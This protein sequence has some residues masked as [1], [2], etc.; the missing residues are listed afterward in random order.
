[1]ARRRRALITIGIGVLFGAV[2]LLAP[3]APGLPPDPELDEWNE[4]DS[5]LDAGTVEA[6]L[7]WLQQRLNRKRWNCYNYAVDTKTF[8]VFGNGVRAHPGKGKKWPNIGKNITAQQMCDKVKA[9]AKLDL[10][11]NVDWD[12][13]DPIPDLPDGENLVALGAKAGPKGGGGDYHWWRLN[14]DGSWS[15][16]RGS[17]K[18]KPTYTDNQGQ[19]QMLTDPRQA[20]QR[21]GYDLCGFMSVKKDPG[22]NVGPLAFVPDCGPG[23]GRVVLSQV[24]LSGYSDLELQLA[25]VQV[26]ELVVFL[27]SFVPDNQVPDPDWG[28]VPAGQPAGFEVFFDP[29]APDKFLPLYLRVF[30][31][32]VE[33]LHFRPD[34]DAWGLFHYNDDRGLEHHL[35][36]IFNLPV[37]ACCDLNGAC[38]LATPCMCAELGGSYQ[39]DGVSCD[40]VTCPVPCPWDLDGNGS[41]GITDL[42]ALLAAW[43]TDPGG[44]PDFDGDGFVGISDLLMLLANWGPC[45]E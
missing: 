30:R 44:P 18:A 38:E 14:G 42:L 23:E 27:P 5:K 6:A 19:E 8:D 39:G 28:G 11:N 45:P 17:T 26:A 4:D 10:L 9:R 36:Q 12:E 13:G 16:K 29:A 43:G 22:P 41:V 1:M 2:A 15:H 20:G 25:D 33:V 7:D 3:L 31:Q 24:V 34:L 32:V 37:G 35:Q 40:D 21:D